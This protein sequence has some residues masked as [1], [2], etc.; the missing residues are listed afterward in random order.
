MKIQNGKISSWNDDKGFGFISPKSG[1]R[2]SL[3]T[4]MTSVKNIKVQCKGYLSLTN[5][6]Q[7]QEAENEQ[8]ILRR[9]I[10]R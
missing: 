1:V 8:S 3:Y 4:L 6:Q 2:H 9:G 7:I 10:R 5:Y